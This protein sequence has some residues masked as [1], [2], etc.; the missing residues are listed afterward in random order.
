MLPDDQNVKF[1]P[2]DLVFAN[3]YVLASTSTSDLLNGWSAPNKDRR[4]LA[5]NAEIFSDRLH[6]T[7]PRPGVT[8]RYFASMSDNHTFAS[9]YLGLSAALSAPDPDLVL[10]FGAAQIAV[11][12]PLE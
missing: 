4:I 5:H 11:V 8:S 6:R 7:A 2:R 9:L 10:I 12:T 3:A 1:P